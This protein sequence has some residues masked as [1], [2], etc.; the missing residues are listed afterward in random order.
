[1]GSGKR[2]MVA[3]ALVAVLVVAG[4]AVVLMSGAIRSAQYG[5]S[6]TDAS[7]QNRLDEQNARTHRFLLAG[8]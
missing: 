4:A 6:V 3:I 7:G 2:K 8:H 5:A 1:M